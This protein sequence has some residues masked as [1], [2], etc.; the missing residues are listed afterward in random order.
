QRLATSNDPHLL[1]YLSKRRVS[2]SFLVEID[3]F[4]SAHPEIIE[5]APKF[6][7]EFNSAAPLQAYRHFLKGYTKPARYITGVIPDGDFF[8]T[9]NFSPPQLVSAYD[10]ELVAFFQD[11]DYRYDILERIDNEVLHA[12]QAL[13]V[14]TLLP[15]RLRRLV[16]Y[17]I[18]GNPVDAYKYYEYNFQT[19]WLPHR[20]LPEHVVLSEIPK[21][22]DYVE[23]EPT[24]MGSFRDGK[25]DGQRDHHFTRL[26]MARAKDQ[27]V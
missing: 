19:E 14:G 16:A 26:R 25:P 17:V 21:P 13:D 12:C 15:R 22:E 10:E 11:Y 2:P 7:E 23:P 1:N 27:G 24:V 18:F 5:H 4:L 8:L 20:Y 9:A 6:V 3:L